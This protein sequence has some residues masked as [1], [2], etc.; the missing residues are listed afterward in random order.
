M[1]R[2]MVR[3]LVISLPLLLLLFAGAAFAVDMMGWAPAA[4]EAGGLGALTGPAGRLVF[5]GWVLE[6]L[7]L[8]VLFLLVQSRN[9]A[10][11][12]L[13]GLAAGGVA[14]L[15]RGPLLVLT[16]TGVGG[17]PREPWWTIAEQRLV[18][19]LLAGLLLA[20][21]ARGCELKRT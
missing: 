12:V 7:S 11:L 3:F 8:L 5:G 20:A 13:D 21:V 16:V 17:L 10:G 14:W 19:Y 9:Q 15:F 18:V 2:L 4:L 1:M 6:A